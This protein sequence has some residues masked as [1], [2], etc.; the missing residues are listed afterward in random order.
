MKLIVLMYKIVKKNIIINMGRTKN[1][2]SYITD[3]GNL[4]VLPMLSATSNA[5]D[6]DLISI[7]NGGLGSGNF[8]VNSLLYYKDNK[9]ISLEG[10]PVIDDYNIL[11][12]S[13]NTPIWTTE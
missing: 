2:Y 4:T 8:V 9:F 1:I 7:T 3:Q 13:N 10:S 5:N 12:Y 6:S 11:T